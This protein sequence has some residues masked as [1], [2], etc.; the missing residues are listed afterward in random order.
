MERI[1]K[2]LNK[3]Y[4]GEKTKKAY[5]LKHEMK[6]HL[7]DSVEELKNE[8]YSESEA[9]ELAIQ[10]FGDENSLKED[11]THFFK[12]PV[13]TYIS[14]LLYLLGIILCSLVLLTTNI[15]KDAYRLEE[16]K[17][18]ENFLLSIEVP[19]KDYNLKNINDYNIDKHFSYLKIFEI[20]RDENKNIDISNNLK[21]G[22]KHKELKQVYS[23]G[24]TPKTPY[25]QAIIHKEGMPIWYMEYKIN[26]IGNL[27]K[28]AEVL[29]YIINI[30][31]III[32]ICIYKIKKEYSL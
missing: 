16:Y 1:D 29:F 6:Q 7:L 17:G 25:N 9:I 30:I 23:Y 24:E 3:L 32:L 14:K 20:S 27:K 19:L 11:L 12:S 22:I 10:E 15:H 2:Y 26:Y 31:L 5:E 4:R 28:G 13:K 8:G 21:K 18:L